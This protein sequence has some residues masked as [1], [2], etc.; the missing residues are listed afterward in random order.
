MANKCYN[1]FVGDIRDPSLLLR[2]YSGQITMTEHAV[3]AILAG[4]DLPTA[5]LT[6]SATTWIN[7]DACGDFI[8]LWVDAMG[9]LIGD[10]GADDVQDAGW[11]QLS[12]KAEEMALAA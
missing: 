1:L 3:L 12:A 10:Q 9:G 2:P 8:D 5:P 4:V 6:A 7:R 11:V